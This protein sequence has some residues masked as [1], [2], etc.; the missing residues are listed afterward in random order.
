MHSTLSWDSVRQGGLF[1]RKT[2]CPVQKFVSTHDRSVN[3]CRLVRV[4]LVGLRLDSASRRSQCAFYRA[5]YVFSSKEAKRD[6]AAARMRLQG[7]LDQAGQKKTLS[8][9]TKCKC[10]QHKVC[11][12]FANIILYCSVI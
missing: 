5:V 9:H 10:T 11:F 4:P 12:H 7:G 2:L 8:Y 6:G 3:R 1:C